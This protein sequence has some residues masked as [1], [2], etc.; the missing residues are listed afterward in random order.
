MRF[1]EKL[2]SGI[3]AFGTVVSFIDPTVTE[4]LSPDLDFVWIDMEHSPQTVQTV[5]SHIMATM[6][7]GITPLVRVAWNDA[8]L[9]KTVLDC[10]AAGVIV[11]MIR[12][13]QDARM[14]VAACKYPP[15]GLRGFGPRRPSRYGRASGPG[16]CQKM[17]EEMICI[18]QIEH[19]DAIRNIDAIV[20][21]PGISSL[22]IGP[23]DLAGSMGHMGE[24]E[25][26]EVAAAID[27]VIASAKRAT[28]PVGIGLGP[29]PRMIEA[30]IRRGMQWIA[31]GSDTS[32]L[33]HALK[34]TMN[35]V[36]QLG[37]LK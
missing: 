30:W 25:H 19:V 16:F 33:M 2:K 24:P 36:A 14:A 9:I 32:L 18:P 27:T 3:T 1:D 21:V 28:L 22:V 15:E 13:P 12:T 8:V 17:N 4:L 29:D 7:S 10:G 26:E 23:N 37:L 34:T 11:P 6:G 5:Q 31:I 20:E 35:S